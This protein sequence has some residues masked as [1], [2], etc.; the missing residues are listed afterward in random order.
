M[1]YSDIG[2]RGLARL[3]RNFIQVDWIK[4]IRNRLL[5]AARHE[6]GVTLIETVLAI[7]IFA[8]VSASIIGVVTS[9]T[10]ADGLARRKTIALELAQQQVE[11]IR[12]L[13]YADAATIGGNPAPPTGKGVQPTSS[14]RVMGLWYELTTSIKYVNDPVPGS[15]VIATFA[16][17]KQV[18]V[19]VSRASDSAQLA[20]VAT[21]LTNPSRQNLG[22]INNAIINV[23]TKDYGLPGQPNLGGVAINLSNADIGYNANDTTSDAVGSPSFGQVTFPALTA[24]TGSG[25]YHV[26]AT[27]P[28][29]VTLKEDLPTTTGSPA[30]V[31]V[32]A[33]D[34]KSVPLRLYKPCSIYVHIKDEL[35]G[36]LYIGQATVTISSS[37]GS[38]QFTTYDGIVQLDAP[39][40]L[41]GEPIVPGSG[42][43][44]A[45]DTPTSRHGELTGLTVPDDYANSILS[46][47]FEVTLLT[48]PVVHDADLTVTVKH[49]PWLT[50]ETCSTG[51]PV[52]T[53]AVTISQVGATP[54]FSQ[55]ITTDSNGLAVFSS[56]PLGTYNVSVS[57]KVDWR[58]TYTGGPSGLPVTT[59]TSICVPLRY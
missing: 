33:S 29:Y 57:K 23:T 56:I 5:R 8:I 43:S 31:Q 47:T 11:Y 26:S 27:L 18:T 6:D 35:T 42:Y 36:S 53:A 49:S 50:T 30:I 39:T 1:P 9:A 16:N 4:C 7:T 44:I 38:E 32:V 20:Q 15:G 28:P 17:Y 54:P 24:G 22:G 34:T 59:D 40:T 2:G 58:H 41:A 45:V 3:C 21:Y 51:T 48:A 37:R 19:T 55:P 12:Q 46:S 52:N 14:K 10:A 13:D 25:T